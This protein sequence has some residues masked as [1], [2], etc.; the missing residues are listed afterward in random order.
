MTMLPQLAQSSNHNLVVYGLLFVGVLLLVDSGFRIV[1]GHRFGAEATINRRLRMLEQGV[2]PREVL[3]RLRSARPRQRDSIGN[4]PIAWL[5]WAIGSAGLSITPLRLVLAMLGIALVAASCLWL[6]RI[7]PPALAGAAGLA[8][9]ISLPLVWLSGKRR[10]RQQSFS[11][12]LPEAIDLLV[13]SLR[14]GHPL[15]AGL[16]MIAEEMP[17]PIGTEFGI[18]VDETTYGLELEEAIGNAT[19]RVDLQDLQFLAMAVRIHNSTGGN[20]AEVLDNLSK[21][22]RSRQQMF[23]KVRAIT[24]EGRLSSWFLS[25]FPVVMGLFLI[26]VKPDYYAPIA[27]D[28]AFAWIV[29]VT[30]VLLVLNVVAMRWLVAIKV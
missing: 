24:A 8:I 1:A 7:V 14:A 19:T 3:N 23:R 29:T 12:Q 16:R 17:D 11:D 25:L 5:E 20:L 30:V 27:E 22:I 21:L 26:S 18:V 13:R 4:S 6:S 2:D 10:R 28:P 9:G 15:S